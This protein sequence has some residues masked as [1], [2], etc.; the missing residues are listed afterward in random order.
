MPMLPFE[1]PSLLDARPIT[2]DTAR[3]LSEILAPFLLPW[4][5]GR[6]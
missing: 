4:P 6:S 1:G 2:A 5:T 3:A